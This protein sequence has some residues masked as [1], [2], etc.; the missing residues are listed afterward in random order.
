MIKRNLV[1]AALLVSLFTILFQ[2]SSSYSISKA[3][4]DSNPGK[5]QTVE[6]VSNQIL[7]RLSEDAANVVRTNS[8]KDVEGRLDFK[9]ADVV[10]G[11]EGL[12]QFVRANGAAEMRPAFSKGADRAKSEAGEK[13]KAKLKRWYVLTLGKE[14]K[15]VNSFSEEFKI[16][17]AQ[18]DNIRNIK[19]VE[20]VELNGILETAYTPNDTYY[21]NQYAPAKIKADLAW[22]L[23]EGT[24]SAIVAII[25]TGIMSSHSD[26]TGRVIGAV[27]F[28]SSP[29]G[30]NDI[31]GHGTHVAG[32]V[33]ANT[34]NST[35][36]AGIASKVSLL[37]VKSLDDGG[38]GHFTEVAN[39]IEWAADNDAHVISMSLGGDYDT[40]NSLIEDSI[41]YAWSEN[42][43][44]VAAGGN[45][46]SNDIHMPA[47]CNHV[48]SVAATD[49]ADALASFSNYHSSMTLAA[50]GVDIYST[51]NSGSY[52][53]KSGTSMATPMVA[54]VAALVKSANSYLNNQEMYD[55]LTSTA[56]PITG[57]GTNWQYG[58]VDAQKAL[59]P[60]T[61]IDE[62][63]TYCISGT[64]PRIHVQWTSVPNA[65]SYNIYRT[66]VG[67]SESYFGNTSGIAANDDTVYSG[68]QY[69]YRI[70]AVFADSSTLSGVSQILTAETCVKPNLNG[71]TA[72]YCNGAISRIHVQWNTVA[73][74][75]LYKVYRTPSGGSESLIGTTS[76]IAMNDETV[77]GGQ[78]YSY[79]VE[80]W[81]PDSNK[82]NGDQS[83]SYA[84]V[85]CP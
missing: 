7:I 49:S 20:A 47:I 82:L 9:K 53:N 35:G 15:K 79:R 5:S 56:D 57:T 23:T 33:A 3:S 69:T 78:S 1:T 4:E 2:L 18:A 63:S 19:G 74:T 22:D 40:C 54:G 81:F 80:A 34:N 65:V 32:I 39:G 41:D 27:D 83:S 24:S 48:I 37:N 45:W 70:V 73:D 43:L 58:R 60:S 11:V 51:L 84:A 76:G 71:S 30:T 31:N 12:D 50:P 42:V 64:D 10:S 36:V 25:D 72:A 61:R 52:G 14:E 8:Q 68:Q 16:L 6:F 67:G 38:S 44:I 75:Y 59:A 26:L 13:S 28:T 29:N 55:I 62:T 77:T 85:S 46:A 17:K 66:A 21:S